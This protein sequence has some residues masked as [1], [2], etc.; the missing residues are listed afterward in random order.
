M[1]YEIK[2]RLAFAYYLNPYSPP[3]M[4]ALRSLIR[5]G[6][7]YNYAKSYG[8]KVFFMGRFIDALRGKTRGREKEG[9]LK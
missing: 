9:E 8:S 5:A 3:Y 7:S 6:Y 4:N 1:D 2:R